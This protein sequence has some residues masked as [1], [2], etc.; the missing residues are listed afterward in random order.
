MSGV[1]CS[2]HVDDDIYETRCLEGGFTNV[3]RKSTAWHYLSDL[4]VDSGSLGQCGRYTT[5]NIN[6]IIT[7]EYLHAPSHVNDEV[8]NTTETV[9]RGMLSALDSIQNKAYKLF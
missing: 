5:R 6:I 4:P 1:G 8:P 2:G 3:K 9:L 7:F